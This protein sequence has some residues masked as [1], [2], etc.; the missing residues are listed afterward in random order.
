M[1]PKFADLHVHT[2][3]SDGDFSPEEVVKQAKELGLAAVGIADHDTIDGIDEALKAGKKYG[4]EA[5]PGVELS[6]EFERSEVH[7]LGYFIDWRDRKFNG[8]LHKF[9]EAQKVRAEKILEKLHKLGI[10]ISHEEVA[11]VAGDG[12][13]GRPH[14]RGPI[15]TWIRSN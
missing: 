6:S 5:I 15:T 12:V 3:A 10:D 7:I 9:Q 11:A 1:T 4:V 13:I 8:E 14:S 2:R